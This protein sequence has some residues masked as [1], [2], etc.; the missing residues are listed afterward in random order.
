MPGRI[1]GRVPVRAEEECLFLEREVVGDE[2]TYE[3][4]RV[5]VFVLLHV[6]SIF[7]GRKIRS[8]TCTCA[9]ATERLI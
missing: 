5:G 8:S 9:G 6:C 3:Y 2:E 7:F 1:C 4:Q